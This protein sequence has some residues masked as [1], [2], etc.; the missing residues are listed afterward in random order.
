M[1]SY[2][3]GMIIAMAIFIAIGFIVSKQVKNAE[4]FYVA[5]RRAP[6]ILITGSLV[7]SFLSTGL[8]MGDAATCYQGALAAILIF[9]GMQGAGYIFGAV[10]FGRYLR[11][12]KVYTIPEFF[13]KRF[14]SKRMRTLAAIVAVVT[15]SVYLLSVMQG[16]GTLME[17]VTGVDYRICLIVATVVF[18]LIAVTSG[19]KGVLITDTLMATLFTMSLFVG[20]V[21]ISKNTGGWYDTIQYL[22]SRVDTNAIVSWA[23]RAGVLGASYKGG[24]DNVIW[25]LVYGIVWMSVCMIGPWQA[26][27][28]QMARSE[29]A[30]LKSAYFAAFG[31]FLLD[32]VAGIGAVFVQRV[33]PDMPDPSRVL[34][35]ASMNLMPKVLGIILLTGILSAGISSATTFQSLIGASVANDIVKSIRKETD[36]NDKAEKEAADKKAINIGR[37]AMITAALIVLVIAVFNPPALFIIMFLGGALIASTWMPVAV[38]CVFSKRLTKTGAFCGMLAGFIG[39]FIYKLVAYFAGWD[40]PIYLDPSLVGIVLNIIAMIAGSAF[41]KVT[42]EEREARL[43]LFIMPGSEKKPEEV[44]RTLLF[45]KVGC[46]VGAAAFIVLMVLWVIPYMRGIGA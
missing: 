10:F 12:A 46:L 42:D 35:W 16:I 21:F 23:G 20:V 1:N 27:R 14:N 22:A 7:A 2:L 34:I 38:A 6:T 13:G 29:H 39:T 26:S 40:L 5:G 9:S 8:F 4:D 28:F 18:S 15:M 33:F 36:L 30:I 44:S 45:M 17:V 43:Q 31:V 37:I 24:A 19:S 25:G 32:F 11:R 3:I 41:T